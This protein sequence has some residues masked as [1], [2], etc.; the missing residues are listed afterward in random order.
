GRRRR[1]RRRRV[2]LSIAGLVALAIAV[3]VTLVNRG[4]THD[5]AVVPWGGDVLVTPGVAVPG[6]LPPPPDACPPADLDTKAVVYPF[7]GAVSD[8]SVAVV[9]VRNVGPR[10]CEL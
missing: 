1:V 6:P 5:S 4:P 8:L 9:G 10:T 2:G 3:P 7:P